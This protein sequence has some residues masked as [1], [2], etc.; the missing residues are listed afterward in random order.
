MLDEDSKNN[1]SISNAN[2]SEDQDLATNENEPLTYDQIL[3]RNMRA[4]G[5]L[6]HMFEYV[7]TLK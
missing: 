4:R 1:S 3:E 2:L 6:C 5:S 7:K